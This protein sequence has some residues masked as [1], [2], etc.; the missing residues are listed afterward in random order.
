MWW[1]VKDLISPQKVPPVSSSWTVF[2]NRYHVD[3]ILSLVSEDLNSGPHL[4]TAVS[5][6]ISVPPCETGMVHTD[7]PQSCRE[8]RMIGHVG[9]SEDALDC[10]KQHPNSK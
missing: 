8:D 9:T 2:G 4:I 10:E 3:I 5:F 1:L 6:S 7:L